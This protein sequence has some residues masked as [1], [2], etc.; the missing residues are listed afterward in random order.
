MDVH[1]ERYNPLEGAG[2]TVG[3]RS[4]VKTTFVAEHVTEGRQSLRVDFPEAEVKSGKATVLI[5]AT[6]GP[7]FDTYSKMKTVAY[8]CHYRWFRCDVYNPSEREVRLRVGA[9]PVVVPP[10]ASTVA[11][12][13]VDAVVDCGPLS[14]VM[15]AVPVR[16]VAPEADVTLYFDH[17]RME[18]EVPSVL[19][20][21]GKMLQFAAWASKKEAGTAPVLWPG[22]TPVDTPKNRGLSFRSC[23]NGIVWGRCD[24]L[25]EPVRIEVPNGRYGVHVFATPGVRY[26]WSKGA[27]VKLNATEHVLF[28]PRTDD[29]V[30][31]AAL[32]GE[33]WDYRPGACV[34]EALVREP[35][36][37]ATPVLY[38]Q[39]TDGKLSVEVPPTL[40]VR[41][42]IVFPEA[43]RV[44]ALKELGRLNFL[45][46]ESWD[47]SHAHV[48]GPHAEKTLTIGFH[49]ESSH[50]EAIPGKLR[51]LK[52]TP[53]EFAR[54]FLVFRRG[55]V[56]AVYPDTIPSP[57]EAR[58]NELSTFAARG[59]RTCVTFSLLPLAEAKGL[60]VRVTDL[61]SNAGARIG[62]TLRFSRYHQKCTEHGHH[63]H[64]Y[65]YQEHF[66]VKR[67][68]LDLHPGAAKRG[69][70]EIAVPADAT[71]GTYAGKVTVTSPAGVLVAE[72]PLR[73]DVLPFQL[74]KPPVYF[75]SESSHAL[76][77]Y[78]GLN[79][80]SGDYEEALRNGF[81]AWAVWPYDASRPRI[82][83]KPLG[84]STLEANRDFLNPLI[85][86]GRDGKGMRL[87]FGGPFPGERYAGKENDEVIRT[88][89]AKM[90]D[91][92]PRMDLVGIT[93]PTYYFHGPDYAHSGYVWERK[94]RTKGKPELLEAARKSHEAFWFV[95]W[96]RH[97][98]EQPAR[99]TYGFWLWKLEAVGKFSTFTYGTDYHYGTAKEAYRGGAE[100]YYTLLGVVGGNA[101]PAH[102][103]SL[104]GGEENPS[105]DLVLI[106][107]GINDYRTIY[108]LDVL[109]A[110]AEKTGRGGAALDAAKKFRDALADELILDLDRY[111]DSRAGAYAENWYVK[112][113][114]PWTTAK[115]DAVRRQ[116]AE[117]ILLLSK[118][119]GN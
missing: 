90:L 17:A 38:A 53:V 97:S 35:Y 76:M 111:Y 28:E 51:A 96:L 66:L 100:P 118:E 67:P 15:R 30:R 115:F 112:S 109:I 70:V 85:E 73:L 33:T 1:V 113:D 61:T 8:W 82:A 71:P 78:Y 65:N 110:K 63:N 57:G 10:G 20:R 12:K 74:E 95:D 72:L 69:Y 44:E 83:G 56:E 107:A 26:A 87:L 52:P 48:A 99:F 3:Y 27:V 16:V 91:A 55:L 80:S 86:A 46:A 94:I 75:G 45:L 25:D 4:P 49:E 103:A 119:L 58:P 43:D 59:Q 54:G 104:T 14:A 24:G 116:C 93:M 50:P 13:T 21:K 6:E 105:R 5:E 102:K 106:G 31:R 2:A 79:L 23:E 88:W 68:R 22:F 40:S 117:R 47:V 92:F 98:K 60:E 41:W 89:T 7:I 36:F 42:I 29:E 18:Q 101:H 32:G 39:V 34:W 114:N 84:W 64:T 81:D 77:R 19:V 62:A 9:V 11:V 37:P 108:T